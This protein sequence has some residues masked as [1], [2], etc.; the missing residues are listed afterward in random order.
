MA[1]AVNFSRGEEIA[2]GIPGAT[3]VPLD[4]R[5]HILIESEPAWQLF[6]E[7]SRAFFK[8]D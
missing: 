4:S 8:S 5:N 1:E 2:K 6:V 3:F 7:G